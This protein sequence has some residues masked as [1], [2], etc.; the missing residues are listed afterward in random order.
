MGATSIAIASGASAQAAAASARAAKAECIANM[1]N[2]DPKTAT[3]QQQRDYASCVFRLHGDGEPM[4]AGAAIALK[5]VILLSFVGAGIGAWIGYRDSYDDW[6]MAVAGGFFGAAAPWLG[7]FILALAA[8][9][10]SFL[11]S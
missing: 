8:A 11:F 2:Y 4:D 10:L 1:G 7:A 3:V 9:G 5:A 6:L